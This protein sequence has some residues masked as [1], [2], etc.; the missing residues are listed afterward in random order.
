MA[1]RATEIA[2]Q[3]GQVRYMVLG[4]GAEGL[5]PQIKATW[6]NN[7]SNVE[8]QGGFKV[9]LSELVEDQVGLLKEYFQTVFSDVPEDQLPSFSDI[10]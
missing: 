2:Q 1:Q 10:N 8:G 7:I 3:G 5:L 4:A 9:Y 6:L